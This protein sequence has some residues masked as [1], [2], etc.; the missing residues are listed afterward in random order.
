[1]WRPRASDASL[2]RAGRRWTLHTVGYSTPFVAAA[3]LLVA[4]NPVITPIALVLLA[5]AWI[6]PELH[7]NRGAKVFRKLGPTDDRAEQTALGLLAGLAGRAELDFLLATGLALEQGQLGT[8]IVG[9]QGAVLVRSGGRRVHCYCVKVTERDL[10]SGD[11]IAHLLLA[12][13]AD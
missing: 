12:L 2:T 4:L 6:V 13:R 1:H 5:H 3:V 7:A 11:R 9:E 10:P 8:W